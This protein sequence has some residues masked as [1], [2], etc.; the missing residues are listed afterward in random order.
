MTTS[1]VEQCQAMPIWATTSV[2]EQASNALAAQMLITTRL[3][4]TT[5]II[6]FTNNR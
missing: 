4:Q 3:L 2:Q 6:T 5:G 1:S